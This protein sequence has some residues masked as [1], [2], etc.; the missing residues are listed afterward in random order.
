M[1][2]QLYF[3]RDAKLYI[4]LKNGAGVHQGIWEV[5][6][7]DGFS[8]SQ[9]TN[10]SDIGLQEMESISGISRRGRRLFT[11]SLAPAEWSFSTYIR[12]TLKSTTEHHL[13][14]EVLWAA[15]AGADTK[16]G[17]VESGDW[18]RTTNPASGDGNPDVVYDVQD[19]TVQGPGAGGILDFTQSNRSIL[20]E[21]TLYF[22]FETST[23]APMVYKMDKAAVNE[24]SIDFDVDGIATANW[25][26]FAK[27]IFDLQSAGKVEIAGSSPVTDGTYDVWLNNSADNILSVLA[28]GAW[29]LA[30]NTG[31]T[32]TSN[33][34]RN[35][36]TQLKVQ[37]KNTDVLPGIQ[38][39]IDDITNAAD[40]VISTTTAH[41]L[42]VGDTVT[43]SG[44]VDDDAG[45]G[46]LDDLFNTTHTV[47]TVP[48]AT[49]FTVGINTSGL[50]GYV[51]GGTGITGKY[52]FTLTGGNVTISNNITYLVPEEIGTINKPLDAVTGSRAI[53]GNFNCYLSFDDTAGSQGN[54]AQF[55]ADLSDPAKGLTK[56]VNNFDVTF[57]V[58]GNT[59]ST[60]RMYLNCPK[61]H[62]DVPV[63]SIE[64]VISLEA[65]FGAYTED[66]NTVDEFNLEVYGV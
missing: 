50:D 56:V 20:P 27:E 37:G 41:N 25:S 61:V 39:T 22:V 29:K 10:T 40:G 64:D 38:I 30:Y 47:A 28:G 44:V 42:E 36:V 62:I 63:H 43:I 3:S 33:F 24:V 5:P 35:R 2:Q 51:S 54:S 66:F 55:F 17:L 34:I 31:V 32:S 53:G 18:S 13:V 12:P 49:S 59:A 15:I 48:D 6:V 8:F 19:G 16:T 21:L 14:D 46:D 9:A 11:D 1:A 7:L 4:E 52:V 58:G 45:G 65:G 57:R 60:P 26:G 23:T